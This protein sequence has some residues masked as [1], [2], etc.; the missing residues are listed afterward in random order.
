M[1]RLANVAR[2]AQVRRPMT[3]RRRHPRPSGDA[4]WAIAAPAD[5]PGRAGA[6]GGLAAVPAGAGEPSFPRGAR[7]R[8]RGRRPCPA[9]RAAAPAAASRWESPWSRRGRWRG[10]WRQMPAAAPG[11]DPPPVR[12]GARQAARERGDY[13]RLRCAGP[14]VPA[15]RDARSSGW[16]PPGSRCR[17]PA[18]SSRTSLCSIYEDRPLVCREHQVTSP[19]AACARLFREPVDRIELPRAAC[20]TRWCGR[21]RSSPA[22]RPPRSR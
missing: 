2:R 1:A 6:A 10:W 14:G 18:R 19:A 17:S 15:G 4:G 5:G 13:A 12:R 21:P 22:S 11:R 9:R 16:P 8:R 20:A 7:R 3:A